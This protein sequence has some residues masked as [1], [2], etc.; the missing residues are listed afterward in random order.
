[1]LSSVG[2]IGRLRSTEEVTKTK[3]VG[4]TVVEVPSTCPRTFTVTESLDDPTSL[5]HVIVYVL[6]EVNE[7]VKK[8]P[9]PIDFVP[10]HPTDPPEA[11]QEVAFVVLQRTVVAPLKGRLVESA[12]TTTVG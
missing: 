3:E 8:D 5:L 4:A 1:V 9:G 10:A 2:T 12:K 11:K 7:P 6:L